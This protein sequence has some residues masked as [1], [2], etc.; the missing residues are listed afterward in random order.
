[1]TGATGFLGSHI[2]DH[3]LAAGFA[4]RASV[5]PTSDLRWL[6]DKPIVTCQ[7]N[8]A[9]APDCRRFL[10]GTV[11]LI[12]CAGVVSSTTAADYH[13]GNVTTTE[14]LLKAAQKVWSGNNGETFVLISS[15]A[16]HGPA[17]LDRPATET[18]P[19]R[20]IT[21]YGRSKAAAEN[22]LTA[23]A[24]PFRTVALRPPALFGPRDR[25][26]LPLLRAARKGWTVQ[27]GRHLQGLSLVDGRD[28]ADAAVIL[29]QTARAHG[30]FFVDDGKRGYSWAELADILARIT[31]RRVRSLS[32]PLGL[33]KTLA[34]FARPLPGGSVGVFRP[35]RI[36]DLDCPGWVCDG[37]HLERTT[38]WQPRYPAAR[39]LGT[40]LAYYL[41]HGWL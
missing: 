2:C 29:L 7:V 14:A 10:T 5:R 27:F 37:S 35:D 39:G 8:L 38:N 9:D 21:A 18:D 28:A 41:E 36:R 22:L 3:L 34:W 6:V 26:F 31:E 13:H 24:W 16:A 4:V 17:G 25:A 40:T 20:P 11:G 15:L 33:L 12:H 23:T 32:I 30:P 19:C 1:L